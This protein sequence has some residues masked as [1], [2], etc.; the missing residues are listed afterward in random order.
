MNVICQLVEISVPIRGVARVI[1]IIVAGTSSKEVY[2][3]EEAKTVLTSSGSF[4]TI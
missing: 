4:S 2:L 1:N 3:T